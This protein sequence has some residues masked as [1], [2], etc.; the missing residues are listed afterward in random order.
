MYMYIV[1]ELNVNMIRVMGDFKETLFICY[2]LESSSNAPDRHRGTE[3]F[4]GTCFLLVEEK[5]FLQAR[6]EIDG[7][8]TDI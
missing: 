2:Y 3:P 1:Y 5:S 6:H 4:I 7:Q 8:S